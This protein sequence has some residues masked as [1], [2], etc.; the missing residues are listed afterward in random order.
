MAPS[1]DEAS[2]PVR[3][4]CRALIRPLRC[5]AS[6]AVVAGE[7]RN[8]VDREMAHSAAPCAATGRTLAVEST[9]N[10]SHVSEQH[11]GRPAK[12]GSHGAHH[13]H[14][15]TDHSKR[16]RCVRGRG[17][18]SLEDAGRPNPGPYPTRNA[19][20]QRATGAVTKDDPGKK[21]AER[22]RIGVAEGWLIG[23]VG[24]AVV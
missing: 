14:P 20:R 11:S 2:R 19:Q 12:R 16:G 1:E 13:F 18:A 15:T 8:R 21:R 7:P 22:P 9:V 24:L 17:G 23:G 3:P 4:P 10:P 6:R 5:W